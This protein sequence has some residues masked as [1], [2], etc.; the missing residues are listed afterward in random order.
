MP[1]SSDNETGNSGIKSAKVDTYKMV[2]DNLDKNVQPHDMRV[3][4]QVRSYHFFHTYA[5]KDRIDLSDKIQ[6]PEVYNL[7]KLLPSSGDKKELL[8]NYGFLFTQT[9]QKYMPYFKKLCVGME[10]HITHEYSSEMAQ[11]SE[12]VSDQINVHVHTY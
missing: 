8:S 11:K 10:W 9:L 6:V 7:K 12:I 5:V 4:I 2:G 1:S 3:D